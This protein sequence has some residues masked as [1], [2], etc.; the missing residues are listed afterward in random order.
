MPFNSWRGTVGLVKP[1]MRPG[2]IEEIIRLLPDGVYV[3][4]LFNNIRAGSAQEF[5]DVI[6]GFE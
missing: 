6:A 3:L 1:T 4:P 5:K 2:Q